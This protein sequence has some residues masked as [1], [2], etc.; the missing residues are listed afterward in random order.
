MVDAAKLSTLPAAPA[1]PLTIPD[2]A[3]LINEKVAQKRRAL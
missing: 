1:A 2:V 3:R